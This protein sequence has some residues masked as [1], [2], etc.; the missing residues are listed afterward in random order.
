MLTEFRRYPI[1]YTLILANSIIYIFMMLLSGN[2]IDIDIQ[3][4]VDMG[5]LYAPYMILDN[6]W[7]RLITSIFLHGGMT[8]LLMNMFSLYLIGRGAENY[9]SKSAYL[10]LYLFAGFL[11]S[12]ASLFMHDDSVG[13]G[14][15]G[16]IFGLFGALAGFFLAYKE[17]IEEH[18]KAFMKQFAMIIGI[19]IIIGLAIPEV[20][21]SAHVGGLVIG[22]IGGFIL[23][24]KPR[25]IWIYSL[26]MLALMFISSRV[27]I[28]QYYSFLV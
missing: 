12:F 8:H 22:F 26:I 7:W 27:L 11:G 9:F 15:S 16:A 13:L 10:S 3:T 6:Q 17:Q 21:V 28:S 18:S 23:S 2:V 4:S 24:K 5:A 25:Y 1:T 20:D 19:N 14:A